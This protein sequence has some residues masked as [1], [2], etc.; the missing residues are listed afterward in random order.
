MLIEVQTELLK[1]LLL[2]NSKGQKSTNQIAQSIAKIKKSEN[3]KKVFFATI[4]EVLTQRNDNELDEVLTPLIKHSYSANKQIA[5]NII[6]TY[7]GIPEEVKTSL[8]NII[9]TE[10]GTETAVTGVQSHQDEP[11]LQKAESLKQSLQ[12][13]ANFL[14]SDFHPKDFYDVTAFFH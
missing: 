6:T 7:R 10:F 13:I 12:H 14:N 2:S 9:E 4:S 11:T 1:E 3:F 5:I 8:L